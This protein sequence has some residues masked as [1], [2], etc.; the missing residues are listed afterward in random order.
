MSHPIDFQPA[1]VLHSRLY[2][3]TS[4]LLELFTRNHGIIP[5]IARGV[6]GS[7]SNHKRALLQPF[8]AIICRWRGRGE[9]VTLTDLDGRSNTVRL[10][11]EALYSGLYVNELLTR[12]IHRHDPHELLFDEYSKLLEQLQN[13]QPIEPALRQFE[14]KLLEELG[15]GLNLGMDTSGDAIQPDQHYYLTTE[16]QFQLHPEADL[17]TNTDATSF[18]G[19]SL[20]AV[21]DQQW[22]HP[23]TLRTAKR[24]IR[25]ALTPLLGDKPL[26]T[27]QLFRS[28]QHGS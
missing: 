14:F 17:E 24:L 21:S 19:Q 22:Q 4:L 7:K 27:R 8:Q 2:R 20:V 18:E 11:K 12:L 28:K 1:F 5:A 16:G 3:E 9:V 15:Y 6:R 13:Q 26:Q 25:L 10:D 23:E